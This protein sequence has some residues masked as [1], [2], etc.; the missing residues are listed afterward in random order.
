MKGLNLHNDPLFDALKDAFDDYQ[1]DFNA[2]DLNADWSNVKSQISA[3]QA[4]NVNNPSVSGGLKSL[5]NLKNVIITSVTGVA[6]VVATVAVLY[7]PKTSDQQLPTSKITAVQPSTD[8]E[9]NIASTNNQDANQKNSIAY[10]NSVKE[11]QN[12]QQ[13]QTTIN[14]TQNTAINSISNSQTNPIFDPSST[15][16]LDQTKTSPTEIQNIPRIIFTE[17]GLPKQDEI[18]VSDSQFCQ[19]QVIRVN[20][21]FK[22]PANQK[23]YVSIQGK[24]LYY[25]NNGFTY[26][27]A[28]A[29]WYNLALVIQNYSSTITK[30]YRINV[31]A[32]PVAS[33]SYN[34]N[35]SPSI[36]FKNLSKYTDNYHW[37]FGDNSTA[38]SENPI[39]SYLD[40]GIYKVTLIAASDGMCADTM[41]KYIT[42]HNIT[43]PE[44]PNAFSPNNDGINDEFYIKI[45]NETLYELTIFDRNSNLVFSSKD[46][47]EKWN[48]NYKDSNK[49][50]PA[51]TYFC[52]LNYK[53]EG[54]EKSLVKSGTIT[55]FR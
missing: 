4:G 52:F 33:F 20:F 37:Q 6:I 48:G 31:V 24:A 44:I 55:L 9:Q 26:L 2:D 8:N 49:E 23:M 17:N 41:V 36:K 14:S 18:Y 51:G 16:I 29:G 42:V 47:T 32:S 3:P 38:G 54:Q 21:N 40:T 39:H 30:L 50:C 10:N 13:I 28:K 46:K 27:F 45:K 35:E 22:D 1:P 43:E 15:R 19:N 25:T 34:L 11:K 53:I 5:L 12:N 7:Q